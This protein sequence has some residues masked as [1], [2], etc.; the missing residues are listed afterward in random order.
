MTFKPA[1]WF[2]IAVALSALNVAAVWFAARPGEAWHATIHAGLAVAFAVWA[3]RLRQGSRRGE[4]GT[5]LG[6][7]LEPFALELDQ[8]RRE[9]SET[10]ERLDFTER[11]LAQTHDPR[12]MREEGTGNRE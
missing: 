9:L 7:Q 3:Q 2:P 10:Q 4:L 11:M 8:M 1:L 6:A 5:Q 12:R